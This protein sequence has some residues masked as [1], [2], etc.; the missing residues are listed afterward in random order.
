MESKKILQREEKNKTTIP[1]IGMIF[2]QYGIQE[3][4]YLTRIV[5]ELGT[6]RIY[7]I[8]L[9]PFG[10]TSQEVTDGFYDKEYNDFFED[11]KNLQIKVI[12]RTMHE[13]NGG[14]YSRSS[15]PDDFKKAWRRVR[16]IARKTHKISSE[17]L[18]FSLSFNSQDL[19]TTDN[20]PTQDSKIRFCSEREVKNK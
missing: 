11:I 4:D 20:R 17:H 12:F 6:G 1:I 8:S 10:F 18:P 5:S 2:D 19:P 7:H 15:R 9:S 14:R 13:M 3:K 16:T